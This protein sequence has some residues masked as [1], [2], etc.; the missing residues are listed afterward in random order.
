MHALHIVVCPFSLGHFVVCPSIYGLPLWYL[1]GKLTHG[2]DRKAFE[3]MTLASL[4]VEALY[5]GNPYSTMYFLE[6]YIIHIS[7]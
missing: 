3:V 7:K 6:I 1:H 5:Q 4:L 2:G